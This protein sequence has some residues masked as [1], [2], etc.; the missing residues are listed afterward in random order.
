[1]CFFKTPNCAI[2][3]N[4]PFKF[5]FVVYLPCCLVSPYKQY[6][7][8]PLNSQTSMNWD[9]VI[10][11]L[12]PKNTFFFMNFFLTYFYFM[13]IHL[14]ISFQLSNLLFK[15]INLISTNGLD[16]SSWISVSPIPP[17]PNFNQFALY[18]PSTSYLFSQCQMIYAV[19]KQKVFSSFVKLKILFSNPSAHQGFIL[20]QAMITLNL[21]GSSFLL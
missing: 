18:F 12:M 7:T 13:Q 5:H 10:L 17:P 21:F 20:F 16:K 9:G 15:K 6:S 14:I 1:M 8:H 11:L 3:T 2:I 19:S 4:R